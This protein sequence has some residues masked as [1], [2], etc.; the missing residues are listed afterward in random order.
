MAK[1]PIG[2]PR[3]GGIGWVSSSPEGADEE[4]GALARGLWG[5]FFPGEVSWRFSRGRRRVVGMRYSVEDLGRNTG[6]R[7][8]V[9]DGKEINMG[10]EKGTETDVVD[11]FLIQW[12]CRWFK[13]ALIEWGSY[14]GEV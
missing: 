3:T 13:L 10:S 7:R 1:L 8:M 14:C 6:G 11:R 4:E 9:Y 2:D 12:L 5:L